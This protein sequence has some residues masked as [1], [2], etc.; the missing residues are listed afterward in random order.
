MIKEIRAKINSREEIIATLENI[1][2]IGEETYGVLK[3]DKDKKLKR[4]KV[5]QLTIPDWLW[6][7][8]GKE[9]IIKD[10]KSHTHQY[11]Y[12]YFDF[13]SEYEYRTHIAVLYFMEEWIT[14]I[15]DNEPKQLSLFN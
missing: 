4:D 9:L 1:D 7:L 13:P 14:P 2:V 15:D 11:D 5:G 12:Y 6:S 10:S 3:S 8:C